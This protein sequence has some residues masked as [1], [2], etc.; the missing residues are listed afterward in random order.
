MGSAHFFAAAALAM[1]RI[2]VERAR[3]SAAPTV[4]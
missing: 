1:R 3:N 4:S 2:L